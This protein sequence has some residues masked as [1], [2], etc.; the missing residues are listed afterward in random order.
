MR[1]HGPSDLAKEEDKAGTSGLAGNAVGLC[2]GHGLLVEPT[3]S[4]GRDT[5]MRDSREEIFGPVT[6]SPSPIEAEERLN[7]ALANPTQP[8]GLAPATGYRPPNGGG[9]P[10]SSACAE[11]IDDPATVW[12][13]YVPTSL[14]PLS[15]PSGGSE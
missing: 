7:P 11:Q 9:S 2:N 10:K 4:G 8:Y 3:A 6:S 14:R 5:N 13:N 1:L 15:A 12:F